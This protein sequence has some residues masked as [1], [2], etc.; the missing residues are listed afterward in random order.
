MLTHLSK[1]DVRGKNCLPKMESES[2][3]LPMIGKTRKLQGLRP[4]A[5]VLRLR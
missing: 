1:T 2:V 4:A 3:H 5:M